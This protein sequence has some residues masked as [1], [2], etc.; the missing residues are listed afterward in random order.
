MNLFV[1]QSEDI[2]P[3]LSESVITVL[4]NVTLVL[5]LPI[6]VL[7]VS[8]QE[9]VPQI[10]PVQKALMIT[11]TLVLLVLITVPPVITEKNVHLVQS[12][13]KWSEHLVNV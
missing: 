9:L 4:T 6:T 5:K 13:D 10:V 11:V 3:M 1:N 7:N 8:H 12:E 2:M